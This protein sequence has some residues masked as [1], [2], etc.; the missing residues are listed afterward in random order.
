V[1]CLPWLKTKEREVFSAN[2]IKVSAAGFFNF[3]SPSFS[4]KCGIAIAAD[5]LPNVEERSARRVRTA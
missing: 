1:F 5:D 4:V 2:S 3:I